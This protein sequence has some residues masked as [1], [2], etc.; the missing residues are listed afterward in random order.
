MVQSALEC[1]GSTPLCFRKPEDKAL[2]SQRT[3]KHGSSFL[4]AE[5]DAELGLERSRY[6]DPVSGR[7]EAAG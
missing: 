2:S 1:G 5:A 4:E 7:C 6:V 3:P